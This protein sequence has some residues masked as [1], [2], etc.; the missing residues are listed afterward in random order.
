MQYREKVRAPLKGV[1]IEA[2]VI[3]NMQETLLSLLEGRNQQT[4]VRVTV[5]RTQAIH[6]SHMWKTKDKNCGTLSVDLVQAWLPD[7]YR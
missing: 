7:G 2:S 1:V 5:G 4:V 6:T 3:G